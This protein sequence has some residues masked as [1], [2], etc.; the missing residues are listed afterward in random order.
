MH[1]QKKTVYAWALYDWANSA[2]ATTVMAGFF[3][4]FFKEYWSN[5]AAPGESTFYLGLANSLA[6]IIVAALSP[7]LGAVADRGSSRKKFLMLFAFLGVIMT[8]SLWLV[9]QGQWRLAVLFYVCSNIGFS[10]GNIFYDALL[11][12]VSSEKK[13]DF[14][15]SLGYALGYIGGGILF[16]VNVMMYLKPGLFGIPDGAAAIRLSFLTVALWWAVFSLPVFLFVKEPPAFRDRGGPGALV[17]GWR[18]LRDT[19]RDIRHLRVV[20]LFLAA[21]WLYIDGVDTIIRMA[22]DYGR[23]LGFD[24][25]SLITALLMVQFIAFPAALAYGKIAERAGTKRALYG[26]IVGYAVITLLAYYMSVKWHFYA[27]AAL[28]GLFQGGIQAL[29]RSFYARLIPANKAAQFFGFYNMLGKFAAVI[30]P[31]MMGTVT[32]VTGNIRYG[33]L[34]ILVLFVLGGLLL[35]MVDPREGRAIADTYL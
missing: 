8:G 20:G 31:F 5:P 13:M 6:S 25:A 34:S 17:M 29:S 14:T 9:D 23:S 26:A 2:F 32:L 15:S 18:Q 35:T 12:V 19:L 21:Y 4:L 1:D 27:L 11:P 33:I 30:G 28:V 22:V 7:F 24:S 16:L 10:G 3:P